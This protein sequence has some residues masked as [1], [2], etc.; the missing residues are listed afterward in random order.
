LERRRKFTRG[1]AMQSPGM[2]K[3]F[4][5]VEGEEAVCFV[6]ICNVAKRRPAQ[7]YPHPGTFITSL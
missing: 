7:L 3:L 2:R 5:L 1:Q 4:S 6:N